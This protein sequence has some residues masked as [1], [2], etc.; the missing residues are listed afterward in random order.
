MVN[1]CIASA[2]II[3]NIGFYNCLTNRLTIID[4]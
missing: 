3:L 4:Y 2:I 1:V